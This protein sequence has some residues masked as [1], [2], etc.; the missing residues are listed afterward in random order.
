MYGMCDVKKV[1]VVLLYIVRS[2]GYRGRKNTGLAGGR[3]KKCVNL[4][5]T[6]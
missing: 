5:V 3:W 6:M 1:K 4:K 2:G